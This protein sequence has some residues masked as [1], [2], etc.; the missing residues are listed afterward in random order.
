M[1]GCG[2]LGREGRRLLILICIPLLLISG[3]IGHR[4]D[5]SGAAAALSG[6]TTDQP[7]TDLFRTYGDSG[8]GWT[9]GDST[10]SIPLPDGRTVWVFSDTFLGKVSPQRSRPHG[11]PY[12][13]NSFVVQDGSSMTTLY[14]NSGYWPRALVS[15]QDAGASYY[16]MGDGTVE[17]NKL[18]VFLLRF[19]YVPL[20]GLFQQIGTD[21]ATFSLPGLQL[22]SISP[23]TYGFTP[24]ATGAPVTFGSAIMESDDGFTYL[25]GVED[26]HSQKYMHLARTRTG[27][28]MGHWQ[29]Y[30]DGIWDESPVGSTRLLSGVANEYSVVKSGSTYELITSNYGIGA[31]LV[32]YRA[33]SPEGP[34][35]G[36]T[37]IFHTPETGGNIFTYNAKA[38][39]QLATPGQILVTYNVNSFNSDDIYSNV[40]NYRPRFIDIP[41]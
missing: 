35:G 30:S 37:V 9:G 33:V 40:D 13:H 20:V 38:H 24:T 16:W 23:T 4:T 18:R 34:W 6:P 11:M 14:D 10:Y 2:W 31:D 3:V 17:A 21:I 19:I 39:P 22:E 29:F 15:P 36:R 7:L 5:P 28:L 26:L 1:Y 8:V 32:R 25:Y 27:D 41:E 12:I